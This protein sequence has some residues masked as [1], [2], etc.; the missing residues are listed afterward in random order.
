MSLNFLSPGYLAQPVGPNVNGV[1]TPTPDYGWADSGFPFSINGA[2]PVTFAID[3]Q[4]AVAGNASCF[5]NCNNNGEI[6]SFHTNGANLLFG[7]GS[8]RFLNA[9]V[10]IATFAAV[11]T[12]AGGE[13][14]SIDF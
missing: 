5:L 9:G 3:K 10:S 11:F 1:G 7:D 8:V 4:S 13:A 14:V 6:Y 2:D 12:K